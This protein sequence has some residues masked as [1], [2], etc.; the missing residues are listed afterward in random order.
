MTQEYSKI[1]CV[2]DPEL[3]LKLS[4][5]KMEDK[6]MYKPSAAFHC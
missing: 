5:K 6:L 4:N 3:K 1:M 2:L